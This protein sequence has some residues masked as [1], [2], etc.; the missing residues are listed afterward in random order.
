[1]ASIRSRSGGF[2]ARVRLAGKTYSKTFKT[3]T[4][5]SRWGT[6]IELGFIEPPAKP[7]VAARY[8]T[9]WQFADRY[10]HEVMT[11]PGIFGPVET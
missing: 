1:M 6:G 5:A 3:E 4:E 2:E 10:G 8:E 9:F 7:E 11:C